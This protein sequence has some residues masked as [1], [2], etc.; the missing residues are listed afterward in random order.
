MKTSHFM[1]LIFL[2][3]S[4]S[5]A[6]S[7]TAQNYFFR[8]RSKMIQINPAYASA[9]SVRGSVKLSLEDYRGAIV[10]YSRVLQIDSKYAE[11]YYFRGYANIVI[12]RKESG[13]LDLSKAG[14]LG[15]QKAYDLIKEYCQ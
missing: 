14:E 11:A 2:L 13:C 10:D 12:G 1:L 4:T 5:T 8:G 9:Y 3:L 6:Y 7:Q 15:Y